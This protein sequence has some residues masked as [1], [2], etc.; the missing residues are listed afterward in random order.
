VI[1]L[2]PGH[3]GANA[4]HPAEIGR[5]VDAGNGVYKACD[6]TGTASDDGHP[7]HALTFAV[8]EQV[9][10]R[11]EQLGAEV[12]LTRTDDAG[13]GPCI[14]ERAATA[15][16]AGAAAALSIHADGSYGAGHRGFH[17]IVG[18][19]A[20]GG[21]A[22]VE[23]SDRLGVLVRDAIDA[24]EMPTSTYLGV[25]GIDRRGD[26]GGLNLTTVPKVFVEMGNMRDA[27]D[28]ALLLDPAWQA[29]L[30]DALT[31]AL[32]AFATSG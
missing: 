26:L 9:R 18:E 22:V 6:T 23:A 10:A 8:A 32:V 11:L 21:P 25:D 31:A 15:N 28:L 7:E 20:A 2:D 19:V 14:T 12:V 29:E 13:W 4:A 16:A 30:A 24:T 27:D 17:V 3:N 5:L 1:S